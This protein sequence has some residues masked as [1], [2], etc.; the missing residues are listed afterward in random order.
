MDG[1]YEDT[2]IVKEVARVYVVH[3]IHC[4]LYSS[5]LYFMN[6]KSTASQ[7]ENVQYANVTF[8]DPQQ[9]L[10]ESPQHPRKKAGYA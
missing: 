7:T 6:R 2:H 10:T 3:A 8:Y 5:Y 1:L 9:I 4:M